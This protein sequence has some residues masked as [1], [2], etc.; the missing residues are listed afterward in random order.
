M[1][2]FMTPKVLD[3]FSILGIQVHS[4]ASGKNHTLA[5]TSNG[6]KIV[7]WRQKSLNKCCVF[8]QVYSWGSS[9]FGQL[10]VGIT[11]HSSHPRLVETLSEE[12]I[13]Q[14]SAGQYHSLA[15]SKS[16]R[17][18]SWGWGVHGQLGHGST[19]DQLIPTLITALVDKVRKSKFVEIDI[20]F[21]TDF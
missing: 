18:Y 13:V 20:S 9:Q 15:I 4:V 12:D 8:W 2:K 3:M 7:C 16:G 6:V 1:A 19:E 14:V 10:G 17:A 5:L 11:S 21:W